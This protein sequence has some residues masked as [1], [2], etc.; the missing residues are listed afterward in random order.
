MMES[1]GMWVVEASGDTDHGDIGY[2]E[3]YPRL[4]RGKS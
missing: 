3:D 2:Y 4:C 1:L